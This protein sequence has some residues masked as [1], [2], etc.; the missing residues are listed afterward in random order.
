MAGRHGVGNERDEVFVASATR[1]AS[2]VSR[3][4]ATHAFASRV[5]SEIGA[6]AERQAAFCQSRVRPN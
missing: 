4:H 5:R 1:S 3:A 2:S 6:L